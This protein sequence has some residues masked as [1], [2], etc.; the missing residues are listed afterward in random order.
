MA[1]RVTLEPAFVLHR[2]AYSNSS[3]IVDLFT[4]NFGRVSALARSARGPKSRYKGIL[5]MFSPLLV[6]WTGQR[7]LKLLGP[8]ELMGMPYLLDR[9]QLLCGF[10]LNELLM[11]LLQ[12]E[13]AYAH[14]FNYYQQ[15]LNRL[16]SQQQPCQITLRIFEKCL[17]NEL[18]YGLPLHQDAETKLPIEPEFYYEYTL[19]Q[20]FFRCVNQKNVS[21][22]FT[23]K[24]LLALRDE[25]FEDE[26]TWD[27][28]KRLMRL[29]FSCLL[30][31]RVIKSRE[32]WA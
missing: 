6:S 21:N 26:N 14:L 27:D 30:G 13:D 19:D 11:R 10:Y 17:L 25:N 2:R 22:V 24:S 28:A 3:W 23:G 5:E 16:G 15:T 4:V 9:E 7:D 18:G 8:V 1:H 31:G 12:K 29:A 32:L 20:G